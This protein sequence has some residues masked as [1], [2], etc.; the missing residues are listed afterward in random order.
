MLEVIIDNSVRDANGC[1]IWQQ[2]LNKDGYGCKGYNGKWYLAHR[3]AWE[4]VNGTIPEGMRVCH[5]CDVT[6]C[7]NPDHLFIGTQQDNMKDAA[8]KRRISSQRIYDE[9]IQDIRSLRSEGQTLQQIADRYS[10]T[11]QAVHKALKRG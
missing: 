4:A 5:K 9:D 6:S 2:A 3:L 11:M 7:V 8:S 10:V 1:W